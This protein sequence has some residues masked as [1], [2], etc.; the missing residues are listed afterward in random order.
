MVDPRDF[1]MNKHKQ[2][3]DEIYGG[4]TGMLIKVEPVLQAVEFALGI[5][6][7]K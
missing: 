2:V 1:A 5:L 7:K 3:D 4:G 6:N